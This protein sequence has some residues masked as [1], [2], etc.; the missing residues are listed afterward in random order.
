[1]IP[2]RLF[3]KE[4]TVTSTDYT[5]A[6]LLYTA[7]SGGPTMLTA[8]WV[9]ASQA[10]TSN[11]V[12]IHHLL[13]VGEET[14]ATNNVIL[15]TIASYRDKIDAVAHSVKLIMQPGERLVAQLHSG[16]AAGISG[17]GLEPRF[18]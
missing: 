3:V 12:R 14:P 8:M 18:A 5:V 10:G 9:T 4:V 6:E 11:Q 16:T 1:M 2:R 17:Y 7:P 15:H 13:P